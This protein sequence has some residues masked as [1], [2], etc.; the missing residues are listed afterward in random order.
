[1]MQDYSIEQP[2]YVSARSFRSLWQEYRIYTDRIELKSFVGRKVIL[3]GDILG[4]EVRPRMVIGD[5]FRGR[6]FKECLALKLDLADL[7]GHV[8]IHRRSGWFKYIR[9]T[10]D[11]PDTFVRICKSIMT[12]GGGQAGASEPERWTCLI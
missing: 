11:D 9:V 1:M 4:I 5:L 3:A 2:L 10:P 7:Y 6:G 12:R 8:A